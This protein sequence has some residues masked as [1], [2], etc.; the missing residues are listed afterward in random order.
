MATNTLAQLEDD[1][2]TYQ[3]KEGE[4]CSAVSRNYFWISIQ[5]LAFI[6]LQFE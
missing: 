6:R 4:I 5:L 2:D 1:F 3:T